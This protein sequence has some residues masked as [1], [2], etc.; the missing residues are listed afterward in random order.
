MAAFQFPSIIV[1][2][3]HAVLISKHNADTLTWITV[4]SVY[5]PSWAAVNQ[6][7]VRVLR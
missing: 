1:L 4:A 2:L 7:V 3:S 6:V 5:N